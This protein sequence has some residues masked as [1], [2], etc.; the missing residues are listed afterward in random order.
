MFFKEDNTFFEIREKSVA[1]WLDEM[2]NHEDIAVRG[3]VK[4]TRD[5]IEA[6]NQKIAMLEEKCELR[7]EYLKKMKKKVNDNHGV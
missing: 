7:E 5:H 1:Q 4:A 3:G 6:L 2:S